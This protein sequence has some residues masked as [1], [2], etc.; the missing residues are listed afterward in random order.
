MSATNY[1]AWEKWADAYDSD[2][3]NTS[4]QIPL[5]CVSEEYLKNIDLT[6]VTAE[7][8]KP[9]TQEEFDRYRA[10][11]PANETVLVQPTKP[12]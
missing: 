8:G 2:G 9:M 1:K 12:A 6:Q 4:L 5:N 7:C 10:S 3:E 11:R